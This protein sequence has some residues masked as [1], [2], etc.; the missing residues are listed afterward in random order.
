MLSLEPAAS[1]Y[2]LVDCARTKAHSVGVK[3]FSNPIGQI[4][5]LNVDLCF[6]EDA[7]ENAASLRDSRRRAHVTLT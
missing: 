3:D 6:W 5:S 4:A 2:K 1:S 7:A